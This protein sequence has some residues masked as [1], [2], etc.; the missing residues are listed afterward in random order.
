VARR[1]FGK[2]RRRGATFT[3]FVI[4]FSVVLLAGAATYVSASKQTLRRA[5]HELRTSRLREAAFTGV[6][7]ASRAAEQ[8][9]AEGGA[10]YRLQSATVDVSFKRA[11]VADGQILTVTSVAK[12]TERSLT[13][14]ATLRS[15]A[16][17]FQ[18]ET[19]VLKQTQLSAR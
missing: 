4:V 1:T 9:L 19:F 8:G 14:T 12:G 16:D 5:A 3:V 10:Q 15:V 2:N 13:C 7:W 18:I 11:N 17:R 6:R